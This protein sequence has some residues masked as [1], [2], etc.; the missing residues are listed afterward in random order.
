MMEVSPMSQPQIVMTEPAA[1][2]ADGL[3]TANGRMGTLVWTTPGAQSSSRS[4]GWTSSPSTA[5]R[6]APISRA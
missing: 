6:R 1:S 5:T 2:P 4:T 3:P